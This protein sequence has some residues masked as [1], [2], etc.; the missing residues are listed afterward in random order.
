MNRDSRMKY[1][2]LAMELKKQRNDAEN[3]FAELILM[4]LKAGRTKDVEQA[5]ED[6]AYRKQLFREFHMD[7]E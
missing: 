3:R 7:D 4:L 1:M 2:T 6:V 5:A